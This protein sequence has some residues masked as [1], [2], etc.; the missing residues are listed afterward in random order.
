MTTTAFYICMNYTYF[1]CPTAGIWVQL[2]LRE[3]VLRQGRAILTR[4]ASNLSFDRHIWGLPP[5]PTPHTQIGSKRRNKKAWHTRDSLRVGSQ[6]FRGI[7]AM[8]WVIPRSLSAIDQLQNF[9]KLAVKAESAV[10]HKMEKSLP[11]SEEVTLDCLFRS[12]CCR[13]VNPEE[14][15]S[16]LHWDDIAVWK[17]SGVP[18]VNISQRICFCFRMLHG[19]V[20][21]D[22]TWDPS[23][24]R[25]WARRFAVSEEIQLWW[26][27]SLLRVCAILAV[28]HLERVF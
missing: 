16:R 8:W 4:L 2:T 25:A 28:G 6:W 11:W 20:K 5:P 14:R 17:L 12:P 19:Q 3:W 9:L 23:R 22:D 15:K 1:L 10:P 26:I 24:S 13:R 7:I 27:E 18:S 21:G